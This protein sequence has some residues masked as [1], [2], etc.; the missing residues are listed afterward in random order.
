MTVLQQIGQRIRATRRDR[1]FTQAGL[2][3]GMDVGAATIS[4]WERGENAIGP[5]ELIRLCDDLG[6]RADYL[7]CLTDDPG[8]KGAAM[9][10]DQQ[11]KLI[12]E[13]DETAGLRGEVERLRKALTEHVCTTRWPCRDCGH[14]KFYGSSWLPE[15]PLTCAVL[16]GKTT[17]LC[18]IVEALRD[19]E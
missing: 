10:T 13:T 15:S 7:L 17:E 1:G 8:A 16:D 14:A 6:V 11:T 19:G 18:P 12:A 4:Q 2:A 3:R 5:Y 9:N